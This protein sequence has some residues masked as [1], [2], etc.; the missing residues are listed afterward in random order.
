MPRS[1]AV[2]LSRTRIS[3][4]L[5]PCA[6]TS[7]AASTAFDTA[8]APTTSAP[9]AMS[10]PGWITVGAP[11]LDRPFGLALWPVFERAFEAVKGYK[12]Q[13]FRF[14]PGR[15]PM[16]TFRATAAM[17]VAYY[18]VIFGGR[19]LM[20]TRAP[21]QLNGPFKVHNL[22]L[23]VISGC[24]L[25]LFAEQLIPT[26]WRRGVFYAICDYK[27]GWT[28]KLVILYYVGVLPL[29][30]WRVA[31]S[32]LTERAAQL[33]DQVPG[34]DRHVLPLPQEEAPQYEPAL[35]LSLSVRARTRAACAPGHR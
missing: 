14:E 3:R 19:E 35:S 5:V 20:R 4:L 2:A 24:L 27:G 23:T 16:S 33:P 15:T 9:P 21:L 30:G 12:P 10:K 29:R 26:L 13:D 22:C 17:L 11:T 18:V 28:D 25:A 7:A 8:T 34:A 31:G 32:G 6:P 1:R